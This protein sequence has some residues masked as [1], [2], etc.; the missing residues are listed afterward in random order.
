MPYGGGSTL[1]DPRVHWFKPEHWARITHF[2][3][4]GQMYILQQQFGSLFSGSHLGALIPNVSKITLTLRYTDWWN[5]ESNAPIAPL[6]RTQFFPLPRVGLPDSV[7]T[8]VVQFES[9]EGKLSELNAAVAEMFVPGGTPFKGVNAVWQWHRRDG[10]ALSVKGSCA[11]GD[12]V[13]TWK[14]D[15]PTSLGDGQKYRHHG[16][17]E[18]MVYVVKEVTWQLDAEQGPAAGV[19]DP[20]E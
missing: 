15:G 2:H 5:W 18:T 10:R 11:E 20:S 1:T 12:G 17:G 8:M 9:R 19:V 7:T 3:I 16:E 4:F 6:A 14:W 13:R